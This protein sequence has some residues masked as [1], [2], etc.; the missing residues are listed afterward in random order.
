M[1]AKKAPEKG[2]PNEMRVHGVVAEL[3]TVDQVFSVS[4]KCRDAG[5]TKW[6]VHTP[7]AVHGIEEAMGIKPTKL[8]FFVLGGGLTGLFG[9]FLLQW[10][11]NAVDYPFIISGKPDFSV[12]ANVP[13]AFETT[14]L[15]SALTAFFAA[16]IMNGLPKL[17]NPLNRLA[18]FNR[19]T[20]DR[21]FVVI[22][23]ADPLFDAEKTPAF[24][25]ELGAEAVEMCEEPVR[26]AGIPRGL[27]FA[28]LCA[29][30]VTF[31]P[32]AI[33]FQWR[34]T[35]SQ[36]PRIHF[37][38]NMDFQPKYKAQSASPL[39]AD[40]RAMRPPVAGAIA[41]GE[42]R[43]DPVYWTGKNED[44]TWTAEFPSQVPLTAA[45]LERGHEQYDIFCAACHGYAGQGNG[46]IHQR[47]AE[48]QSRGLATWVQPTSLHDATVQPRSGETGQ[49]V[50]QIF[51]SITHG[52]RSMQ[53]YG[54][55]ISTADRWAIIMYIRAMQETTVN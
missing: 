1:S 47:A 7:F 44:G 28:A 40:G 53:P 13:V 32:L 52:I 20:D 48:L 43:D 30:L 2:D 9:G 16:L 23:A 26:Q 39:F 19:V 8:P 14:I 6:D 11:T 36:D 25:T 54:G 38:Q 21:F 18:R 49:H 22:E 46:M 12:P 45:T 42:L 33:A 31:V 35:K 27:K 10:W 29:V 15:L 51:N 41:W 17:Y 3:H 24:L 37:I 50:G 55:Q 34:G 5:F 4:E